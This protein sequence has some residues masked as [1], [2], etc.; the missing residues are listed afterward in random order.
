MVDGGQDTTDAGNLI[1]RQTA[2]I[3][4]LGQPAKALVPKRA[5][6]RRG[7]PDREFS[8]GD[9]FC[10]RGCRR[11]L[12]R[13]AGRRGNR[14]H[15]DPQ[16][17]LGCGAAVG[18]RPLAP[19]SAGRRPA[20]KAHDR[21]ERGTARRPPVNMSDNCLCRGVALLFPAPSGF[22]RGHLG[23]LLGRTNV[24]CV[25]SGSRVAQSLEPALPP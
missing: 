21:T 14:L 12:P 1:R 22:R 11:P 6:H 5:N 23:G 15:L 10:L 8:L 4:V 17:P 3:V 24:G 18:G 16:G 25:S 9:R 7:H 20:P 2:R 19:R 13:C